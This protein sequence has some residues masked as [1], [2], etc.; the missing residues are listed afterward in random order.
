MMD[1]LM[2]EAC[3]VHKKW[4]KIASDIKLAFYSSTNTC[5]ISHEN[6]LVTSENDMSVLQTSYFALWRNKTQYN[7][8]P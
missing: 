7:L 1:I 8:Q 3:W 5:Y 6:D 2:S 4:N